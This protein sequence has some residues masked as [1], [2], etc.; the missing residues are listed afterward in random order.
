M[1]SQGQTRQYDI[2]IPAGYDG[3]KPLAMTFVLDGVNPATYGVMARESQFNKCTSIYQVLIN[4][5]DF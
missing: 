2:H 4:L 1:Q 3:S 5:T